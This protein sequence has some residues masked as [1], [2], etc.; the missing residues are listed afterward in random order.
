[1]NSLSPISLASLVNLNAIVR[2]L[3]R[4]AGRLPLF[5]VI[6]LA[7]FASFTA[8]A[9]AAG[10]TITTKTLPTGYAGS[11]YSAVLAATGGSGKGYTWGII[12]GK[13]PA[14]LTLAS[15]TGAITGKPTAAA[16]SSFTVKVTD[17]A[18]NTATASVSIKV[19]AALKVT[20]AKLATGYV[21][22]AFSA[23]LAATGGTETGYKWSISA[24]KLPAGLTLA[25]A[26]GAITGKPT[27]AATSSFTVKVTDSAAHTATASLS[28]TVDKALEVTTAKL[29]TGYVE[30][31]YSATLAATGGTGTGYKWSIAAGT[32]PT[33]LSLV[34]TTGVISG[35]PTVK[36]SNALTFK[37]TDSL[38]HT[39]SAKFTLEVN[40][41]LSITTG[42]LA[43]G[44]VGSKYSAK[45]TA[46]GGSGTGE[47]WSLLSG[48]IPAGVTLSKAGLL[49][50]TPTVSGAKSFTV[51]VK[52]S[53]SNTAKATLTLTVDP[54]LTVTAGSPLP[55][56]YVDSSYTD[57]LTASGGTGTGLKWKATDAL[58]SGLTLSTAG[59]LSGAPSQV[60]TTTIDVIVTDSASNAATATLTM[61]VD[62][63]VTSCTNDAQST[64]LVELFGVYTFQFNRIQ[65]VNNQRSYSIGSF[66]ADGLGNIVN[67]VMDTKGPEFPSEVQSTFK[68]SYTVGSDGRGRMDV[69]MDGTTATN[70]FCFALDTFNLGS[71]KETASHAAVMEDDTTNTVLSGE[72]IH[73]T[74][75]PSVSSVKGTWVVGMAGRLHGPLSGKPDYR[76]TVAGFITLDGTGTVSGGEVD[77][78]KDVPI[79]LTAVGNVYTAKTGLTG[80]YTLPT[81]ASGTPTGRGTIR[82]T[83]KSGYYATFVF[84][85]AGSG[86]MALLEADDGDPNAGQPQLVLVGGAYKRT[87]TSF[88]DSTG[89]IGSSVVANYFLTNVGE[90]NESSGVG[91]NVT[92]WDGKGNFTYTGDQNANGVA[93]T[94]SG[95]GTYS[96]DANGR[97]AIMQGGVCSP[98][99]YL[100]IAN[101]GF[102]IWD[103]PGG[104]FAALAY[105]D[106]PIGG[107]FQ[108]SGMQGAYSVGTRWFIFPE[109]QTLSGE[110]ISNGSG[111]I[112]GTLDTNQEGNTQVNQAVVETET[113][114]PT[115]GAHGRFLLYNNDGSTN[116]ALYYINPNE[117]LTIQLSPSDGQTQPIN[118]YLHQ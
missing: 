57:T 34:A 54:G 45:L 47:S 53:A 60:A 104:E 100:I 98:C 4:F 36:G 6:A 92:V 52:D 86:Y 23:T 49:S 78:N 103:S 102:A 117:D 3:V 46:A 38:S 71:G 116:S 118:R 30:I 81:P 82:I 79:S 11:A 84:Y 89:L 61:V 14:G 108:L 40:A 12:T 18:A 75:D 8:T 95:K 25:S 17:S 29:A 101:A 27:A 5:A 22:S 88:S 44:Y 99:G 85:P 64:A 15:A 76:H 41:D 91:L 74:A 105:Q 67:G 26:T 68:G 113:T 93:T 77:Q 80:N 65:L 111:H 87:Q 112:T 59:V 72:L 24:G 43:V 32:L 97:F 58:P 106:V 62:P 16:T 110:V 63:K 96:V 7:C 42:K 115:S 114:T 19:N 9:R 1:M 37:V 50:G 109:Q 70:T 51:E 56:G 90:A 21:G 2:R 55:V 13:I 20:T 73:Q 10:L 83:D 66:N 39:A 107:P 94:T 35:K 48:A 28:I 69:V 33:G 31:A